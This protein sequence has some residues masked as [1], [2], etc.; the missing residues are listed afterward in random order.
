MNKPSSCFAVSCILFLSA[1]ICFFAPVSQGVDDIIPPYLVDPMPNPNSTGN[2]QNCTIKVAVVDDL[3]GVEQSTIRMQ[4]N[5][6]PPIVEPIIEPLSSGRGYNVYTELQGFPSGE[7][8]IVSVSA[9]DFSQNL[10]IESWRFQIAPMIFDERVVALY[11]LDNSWLDYNSENEQLR[12]SWTEGNHPGN[13]RLKLTPDSMPSG[14]IDLDCSR[15]QNPFG[16]VIVQFPIDSMLDW[17]L[18]N[19]LGDITWQVAPIDAMAGNQISSYTSPRY[20][21]YCTNNAPLLETPA[22]NARLRPQHPPYISWKSIA[23]ADG[24][25]IIFVRL[26]ENSEFTSDVIVDEIPSLFTYLPI[27]PSTWATFAPGDWT[28]TAIAT[29]PDGKLSDYMLNRFTKLETASE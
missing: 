4:I 1:L 16:I 22:H 3:S 10:M 9:E 20:L 26:N 17:M 13:Y 28:W 23:D 15:I 5:G 24:Y 2:A 27:T 21:R 7:T 18:L 11:P 29:L 6:A 14:T 25:Y 19:S 8:I 12:F